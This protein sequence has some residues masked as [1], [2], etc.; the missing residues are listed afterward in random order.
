MR[1]RGFTQDDGHIFCTE[2]QILGECVA[3]TALLRRVYADF[4]FSEIIYKVAT[5]PDARIGSDAIW[6]KA[7]QALSESLRRS[8]CD[9][10]LSP[11]EGA[12]YGPKIEYTL[13]DAIGREWQCGTMQVD[14]S[15]AGLL[16]AEY[17]AE[18]GERRTPV[19]LHRAIVGSLERFIGILIE[20]HAGAL[21]YG[22]PR[23]QW[24]HR[25]PK[26]GGLRRK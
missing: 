18:S 26:T 6:D 13:K 24:W 14:F 19:M 23:Q 16:G 5:R 9:F 4:G 11:G 7:E 15:M 2:E 10:K 3:Y 8:G 25:S 22:C 1:V 17:V 12:F 20:Q 21:P